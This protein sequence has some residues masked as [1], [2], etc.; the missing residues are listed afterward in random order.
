MYVV[1]DVGCFVTESV[2]MSGKLHGP[3]IVVVEARQ[4]VGVQILLA[5]DAGGV[6]AAGTVGSPLTGCKVGGSGPV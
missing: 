2:P 6:A 5:V 1:A 3:Q 4:I